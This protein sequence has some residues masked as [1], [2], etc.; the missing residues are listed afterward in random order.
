MTTVV[1]V[2]GSL[3]ELPDL[4]PRLR[5]WLGTLTTSAVLIVPGGGATADVIRRLDRTHGLGEMASHQLALR[6]MTVNAWF[7]SA[8][9]GDVPVLASRWERVEEV[10]LLDAAAFWEQDSGPERLPASWDATSDSVAARAAIVLRAE[11]LVLLKSV[12]VSPE[13]SWEA[14]ARARFV[15]ALFPGLAARIKCVRVV[16]LRKWSLAT[17]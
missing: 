10:S 13:M 9:L 16:N 11:E 4:G 14:A 15:D 2:G 7:L 6:A 17:G 3:Y 12:D 5:D 1:K 8:L